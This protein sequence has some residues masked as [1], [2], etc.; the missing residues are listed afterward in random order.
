MRGCAHRVAL[1][2]G[3]GEQGA[4]RN[5]Q[6]DERVRPADG[7]RRSREH[8]DPREMPNRTPRVQ[9]T[10]EQEPETEQRRRRWDLAQHQRRNHCV[11]R[12]D[13]DDERSERRRDDSSAC[14]SRK[15]PRHADRRDGERGDARPEERRTVRQPKDRR[16]KE[17]NSPG[18]PTRIWVSVDRQDR[19]TSDRQVPCDRR[20]LD[21]VRLRPEVGRQLA[22]ECEPQ[23]SRSGEDRG[24][25]ECI[26]S[27]E[28]AGCWHNGPTQA[29]CPL[30]RNAS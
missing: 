15:L 29:T 22:A 4:R 13:R 23:C 30:R 14:A 6:G 19:R 11:S 3:G 18:I 2:G 27:S 5:R 17:R 12:R 1:S 16:E 25:H 9:P 28:R 10:H 8:A 26:S 21:C 7:H 24:A 20:V